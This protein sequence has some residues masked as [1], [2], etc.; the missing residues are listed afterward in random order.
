MTTKSA[1]HFSC[2]AVFFRYIPKL[3]INNGVQLI[4]N[5]FFIAQAEGSRLYAKVDVPVWENLY[6][7]CTCLSSA[8]IFCICF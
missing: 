3:R 7:A 6:S 4:K 2:Y 5:V 8:R 1:Q